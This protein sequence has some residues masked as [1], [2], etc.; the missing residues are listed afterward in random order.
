MR[1]RSVVGAIHSVICMMEDRIDFEQDSPGSESGSGDNPLTYYLK[2]INKIPL[3][4]QEDEKNCYI[5]IKY[6]KDKLKELGLHLKSGDITE[7]HYEKERK[8]FEKKLTEVKNYVITANLRLV[9]SIAKKFQHRGL[10]LIDLIDEGN[11]GLIEAIDRFDYTKG[12]KFST[13]GTWWI[14]QSII[15]AIADKG[16]LIR[17]PI[18][19]LNA[20]KKCYYISKQ[21]TQQFG[22]EPTALEISKKLGISEEKVLEAF[23]ISQEPGSLEVH[24]NEDHSTE[25][26]DFIV[27]SASTLHED[28]LFFMALQKLIR[29]VLNKLS[30]R[31]KKIIELRFGLDGEGPY[32]LEETGGILGITRERVRQIQNSALKKV[33][34]F[35]LSDELREF[36]VSD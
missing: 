9:V 12:Y 6:Y 14:R 20:I 8:E 3:M 21:L 31:E 2:Q 5:R 16:R 35:T 27:D 23:N 4:D 13:Y 19:M 24:V 25:L 34:N 18:H 17:V 32:T 29:E 26:G 11:I 15:K 10:S 30:S 7:V 36:I 28:A 33:K 22:R 1:F